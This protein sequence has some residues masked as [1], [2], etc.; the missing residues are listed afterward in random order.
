M[1][2]RMALAETVAHLLYLANQKE[3]VAAGTTPERWRRP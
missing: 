2:R 3:L 1:M